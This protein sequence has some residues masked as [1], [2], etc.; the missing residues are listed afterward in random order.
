[1]RQVEILPGPEDALYCRVYRNMVSKLLRISLGGRINWCWQFSRT[2]GDSVDG[3]AHVIGIVNEDSWTI[4][5]TL[6]MKEEE[7]ISWAGEEIATWISSDRVMSC[8]VDSKIGVC[9]VKVAL[10]AILE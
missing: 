2:A 4:T 1:M 7:G 8:A 5:N 9:E 3:K 6:T 10:Q